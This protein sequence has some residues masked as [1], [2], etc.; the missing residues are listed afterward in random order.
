ASV[1]A[2]VHAITVVL[3]LMQPF[4]ALRRRVYQ[5]AELW[6]DPRWKTG[7]RAARP[8]CRRFCHHSR[9]GSVGIYTGWPSRED[10]HATGELERLTAPRVGVLVDIRVALD[11]ASESQSR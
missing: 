4:R 8:I 10:R 2:G 7:R 5:F 9:A 6:L 1:Q 11:G 3:D